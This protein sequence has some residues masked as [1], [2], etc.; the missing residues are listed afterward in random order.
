[1]KTKIKKN[2]SRYAKT[3]DKYAIIQKKCAGFLSKFL[4]RKKIKN[5]LEIGPGTGLFT[6]LLIKKYP[7]SDIEAVEISK[8][9]IIHAKQFTKNVKFINCD[10]EKFKLKKY[11]LI[12][13]SSTLHWLKDLE[14]NL[15]KYSIALNNNGTIVCSIFSLGTFKELDYALK[16]K[17]SKKT[18]ITSSNFITYNY[19]K[20]LLNK[21]FKN[22]ELQE[23]IIKK[24]CKSL[25]DL[26]LKIKY[27][28][29]CGTGLSTGKNLTRK[30][31]ND[32]EQIYKNKY[33]KLI[34]SY[35]ILMFNAEKK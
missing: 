6:K 32:I 27:T 18:K 16:I 26:L 2:F 33:N 20:K 30:D 12:T 13:S 29:T 21:Y 9:M 10:A 1:M 3:Y 31:L 34:A 22:I 15:K 11:D 19:L 4:P 14:N 5:I 23:I 24:E 8:E 28:G 35:H 25:Y 17:F 7:K